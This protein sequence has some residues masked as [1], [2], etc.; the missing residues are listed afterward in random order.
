MESDKHIYQ[1]FKD[2]ITSYGLKTAAA[3][4]K[5]DSVFLNNLIAY[6]DVNYN[7]PRL[8][9]MIKLKAYSRQCESRLKPA[10]DSGIKNTTIFF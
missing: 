1:V 10:S 9:Y 5:V 3:I 7:N 6:E 4:L 2:N 8:R